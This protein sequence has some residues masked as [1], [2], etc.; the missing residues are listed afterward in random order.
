MRRFVSYDVFTGGVTPPALASIR[1]SFNDGENITVT[2]HGFLNSYHYKREMQSINGSENEKVAF[3]WTFQTIKNYNLPG[4]KAVFIGNKGST[5]EIITLALLLTTAASQISHMLLRSKEE[6]KYFDPAVLY[7]DT[8]PQNEEFWKDIF[9]T[10]LETKP[11]LFHLLHRIMDTLGS[12]CERYW[13]S[14]IKLRKSIYTYF[15]EDEATLLKALKD[16]S[17]SKTGETLSG[18]Q[19]GF[20]NTGLPVLIFHVYPKPYTIPYV[21]PIIYRYIFLAN[22]LPNLSYDFYDVIYPLFPN[23]YY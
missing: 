19:P 9:Q 1:W 5:K 3:D 11:G 14:I 20:N 17:F 22:V 10:Y 16:G 13:K 2:P 4:A 8:C 6:C 21:F 7:M 18:T 23:P 15:I 12:K